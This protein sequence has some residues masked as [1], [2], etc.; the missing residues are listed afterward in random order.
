MFLFS[1]GH[2]PLKISITFVFTN[3]LKCES[4]TVIKDG[5]THPNY[6]IHYCGHISLRPHLHHTHHRAAKPAASIQHFS[7]R[8]SIAVNPAHLYDSISLSSCCWTDELTLT[9]KCSH[10]KICVRCDDNN[11]KLS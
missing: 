3:R 10:N 2:L 6:S 7:S 5:I 1:N 8:G 11:M 9:S 4:V